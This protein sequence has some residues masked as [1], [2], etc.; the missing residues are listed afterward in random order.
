MLLPEPATSLGLH[1]GSALILPCS[2][3]APALA[4]LPPLQRASPHPPQPGTSLLS[5]QA[6]P[7]G[8]D[9]RQILTRGISA[10]WGG[11]SVGGAEHHG[12]PREPGC[13]HY[14]C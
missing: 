5:P 4:M 13:L 3:P 10:L 9:A 7:Q 14:R 12:N 6:S 8:R 1:S 2:C 11:V